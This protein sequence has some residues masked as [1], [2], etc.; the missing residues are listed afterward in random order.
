MPNIQYYVACQAVQGKI[1]YHYSL[2]HRTDISTSAPLRSVAQVGPIQFAGKDYYG[3]VISGVTD[4]DVSSNNWSVFLDYTGMIGGY[5]G[6][7]GGVFPYTFTQF[8]TAKR[9]Y[10]RLDD[11]AG[12]EPTQRLLGGSQSEHVYVAEL[13]DEFGGASN[14]LTSYAYYGL[15]NPPTFNWAR[16]IYIGSNDF[17]DNQV[18]FDNWQT[19]VFWG[20]SGFTTSDGD[21]HIY[22]RKYNQSGTLIWHRR[23]SDSSPAINLRQ[24]QI[25]GY[26]SGNVSYPIAY[27]DTTESAPQVW[28][29]RYQSGG[30]VDSTFPSKIWTGTAEFGGIT[31]PA[32]VVSS[33]P[34]WDRQYVAWGWRPFAGGGTSLS[35]IAAPN[36]VYS[37][38]NILSTSNYEMLPSPTAIEVPSDGS[39]IIPFYE[40]ND[41]FDVVSLVL[42]RVD[43]LGEIIWQRRI[44]FRYEHESVERDLK[45]SSFKVKWAS[46]DSFF[47]IAN[48]FDA[49]GLWG[50]TAQEIFVSVAFP[51]NGSLKSTHELSFSNFN[52]GS[53]QTESLIVDYAESSIVFSGPTSETPDNPSV[54][55]LSST[56]PFTTVNLSAPS[57]TDVT[58]NYQMGFIK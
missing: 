46:E 25:A 30:T 16:K 29:V 37:S 23:L 8:S 34:A 43:H 9:P 4:E 36:Y 10:F 58:F 22:L 54:F 49:E 13:I 44:S 53:V 28:V 11:A 7:P 19:Y 47:V 3:L 41:D 56:D 50:T 45:I 26:D 57:K 2:F 17:L 24:G 21:Q 33:R 18:Y 31:T 39:A 27:Q 1:D 5:S 14:S 12:A 15:I 20:L 6:E 51:F 42:V 35:Y 48:L 38:V 55:T 40:L 32:H 52:G